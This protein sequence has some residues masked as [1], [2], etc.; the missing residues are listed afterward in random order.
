MQRDIIAD[1][2]AEAYVQHYD[3]K[4]YV[5]L[6]DKRTGDNYMFSFDSWGLIP[7]VAI[8]MARAKLAR[9]WRGYV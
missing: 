2:N 6:T 9:E 5:S 1:M 4:I 3:M 7:V 8:E